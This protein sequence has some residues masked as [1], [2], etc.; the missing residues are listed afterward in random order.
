MHPMKGEQ[1][2]F[3]KHVSKSYKSLGNTDPENL[4][5]IYMRLIILN[6]LAM[7]GLPFKLYFHGGAPPPRPPEIVDLRPPRSTDFY[8]TSLMNQGGRRPTI[9]GGLGGGAPQ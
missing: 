3:R 7:L 6:I 4:Y 8:R 2:R 5:K 9:S 1:Y